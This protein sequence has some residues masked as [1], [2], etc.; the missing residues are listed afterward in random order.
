[1]C[2][3]L[4]TESDIRFSLVTVRAGPDAGQQRKENQVDLGGRPGFAAAAA[5]AGVV[6]RSGDRRSPDLAVETDRNAIC[7]ETGSS[8]S[9]SIPGAAACT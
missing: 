1:V 5:T 6:G 9:R 8:Y 4:E 7:F 3:P 2:P